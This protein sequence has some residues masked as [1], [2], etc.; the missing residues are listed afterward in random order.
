M[1]LVLVNTCIELCRM[2]TDCW[3]ENGLLALGT[4]VGRLRR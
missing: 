1:V 4:V 2:Q 3:I